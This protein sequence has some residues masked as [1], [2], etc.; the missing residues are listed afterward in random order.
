[1]RAKLPTTTY[2][3]TGHNAEEQAKAFIV[4]AGVLPGERMEMRSHP[5]GNVALVMVWRQG[6]LRRMVGWVKW[7]LGWGQ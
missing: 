2:T 5:G 6:L 4:L 7:A 3:F 1:M